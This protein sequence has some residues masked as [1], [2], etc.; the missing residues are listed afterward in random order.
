MLLSRSGELLSSHEGCN[1]LVHLPRATLGSP[2]RV[3]KIGTSKEAEVTGHFLVILDV[4]HE[5]SHVE[6]EVKSR[7][8]VPQLA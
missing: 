5:A 3:L 7:L 2:G 6:Y 4:R 1:G 8:G